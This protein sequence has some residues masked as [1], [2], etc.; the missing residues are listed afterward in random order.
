M[1]ENTSKSELLARIKMF[2]L[3]DDTFMTKVFEE[4]I[5]AVQLLLSI[6]LDRQDLTVQ[7]VQTQYEIKNLQGRSVRFDVRAVDKT[8]KLYDIE[9]Q[10]ADTGAGRK[11]SR[12]NS[13]VMDA[14]ALLPGDDTNLL[15]ETYVIFITENDIFHGGY[16]VYHVN[17]FIEEM[18]EPFNDGS[19][20]LY[21]NGQYRANN[22]IGKLMA[23]FFCT[24]ADSMHYPLLASRV[25]YLKETEEGQNTMCEIMEELCD[26]AEIRGAV[27]VLQ[28]TGNSFSE[29][30]ANICK[31]FGFAPEKAES[32]VTRY[33][34]LPS[35]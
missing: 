9:V 12:Y 15:P 1:E 26:K 27:R 17:R 34:N 18:N 23:D 13:S 14:N 21:V 35:A 29:A 10:R 32:F 6:I 22:P 8:G 5:P 19:H 30:V 4:N 7:S 24:S 2:R 16:P 33:W 20:I 31:T 25:R 28:A 11:R 3:I